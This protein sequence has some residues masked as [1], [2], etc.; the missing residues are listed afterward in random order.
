MGPYR[1]D[2]FLLVESRHVTMIF[3]AIF[4]A[5]FQKLLNVFFL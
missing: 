3:D 1:H 2:I 5:E 4:L